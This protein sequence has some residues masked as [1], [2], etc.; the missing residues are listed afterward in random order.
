MILQLIN[1]NYYKYMIRNLFEGDD[2]KH[3]DGPSHKK[4][5]YFLLYQR[6]GCRFPQLFTGKR[7][8]WCVIPVV[9]MPWKEAKKTIGKQSE[10][11]GLTAN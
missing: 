10:K 1:S 2:P 4:L 3:L 7:V 5:C 9:S 11:E 6:F 8:P